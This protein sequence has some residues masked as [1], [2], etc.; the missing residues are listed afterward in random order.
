MK[1][2]RFSGRRPGAYLAVASG[3]ISWSCPAYR[4]GR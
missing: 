1:N 3:H 2:R 4:Q